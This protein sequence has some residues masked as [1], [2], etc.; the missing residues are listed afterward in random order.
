MPSRE[1]L[2]ISRRF[3][4]PNF[5][6]ISGTAATILLITVPQMILCRVAHET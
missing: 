2:G 6:T 3:E 5:D 1:V 4:N